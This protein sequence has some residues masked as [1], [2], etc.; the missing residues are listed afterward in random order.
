MPTHVR[1]STVSTRR[2]GVP[3]L[4]DS[5]FKPWLTSQAAVQSSGEGTDGRWPVL[6]SHGSLFL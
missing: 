3:V 5:P 6:V 2:E 1:E 4:S